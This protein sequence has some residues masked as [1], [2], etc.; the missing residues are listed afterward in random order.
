MNKLF[1]L[2]GTTSIVTGGTGH[3]GRYMCAALAEYG[4]QVVVCSTSLNRAKKFATEIETLYGQP[5]MGI[6]IDLD[7]SE[8]I[9][10]G[11]TSVIERFGQINCLINN[12]YFGKSNTLQ[13]MTR[14]EWDIGI[15]GAITPA[16]LMI[17]TCL[18]HL[19]QTQGNI[20]NISSMYGIVSPDPR[21]YEGNS[22]GNPINYGVGKAGLIQMTRY[23]A[24]HLAPQRIRV[25]AI[26]PGP[27]PSKSV[28]KNHLFIDRLKKKVPLGRIGEPDELK[29]AVV[30]L[31]S[32]SASY[33]TGHNLVVDGGW[34][35]W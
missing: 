10:N 22:F 6:E 8:S 26:S 25:N 30:F 27:F 33:I 31:V 34:T 3:L 20:I 21:V 1:D 17:Q 11:V 19:A 29:G 2:S 32:P 18:P 9:Q 7:D 24:V 16:M 5:S 23:M 15:A 12:A 28:Q 14:K 35:V 13:A 4:S